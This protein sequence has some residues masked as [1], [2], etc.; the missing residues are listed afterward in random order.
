[1]QTYQVLQP[2]KSQEIV[3]N[4][5]QRQ[6]N[7]REREEKADKEERDRRYY[8]ERKD[9][10][11]LRVMDVQGRIV[12]EKSRIAAAER[13]ALREHE[14]TL[15]GYDNQLANYNMEN[16]RLLQQEENRRLDRK[17]KAMMTLIA[18]LSNLGASFSV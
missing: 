16:A 8:S 7:E 2:F 17:E 4:D 10:H 9:A 18:S 11:D 5:N 12:N 14:A 1:M 3:G 13:Q 6:T 15:R